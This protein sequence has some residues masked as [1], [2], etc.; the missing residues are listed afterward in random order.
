MDY[1]Y[2]CILEAFDDTG[3]KA[4]DEQITAVAEWVK[5]SHDNYGMHTGDQYIPNPLKS[6]NDQLKRKL[7]RE[8]NKIICWKCKGS[9]KEITHGPYHSSYS[10]CFKCS[11]KGFLY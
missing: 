5:C 10:D 4:T 7:E 2:D 8:Q 3:I 1:W 9:G 11:G 6:E